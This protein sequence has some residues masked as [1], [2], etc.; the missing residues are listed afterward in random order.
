MRGEEEITDPELRVV[1]ERLRRGRPVLG[2]EELGRVKARALAR[3]EAGR[4]GY[5]DE[6][7]RHRGAGGG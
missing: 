7:K 3:V 5:T 2:V 4:D 6:E 1:A